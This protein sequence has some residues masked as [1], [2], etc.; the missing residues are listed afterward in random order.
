MS[1]YARGRGIVLLDDYYYC[2]AGTRDSSNTYQSFLLMKLDYEGEIIQ[3]KLHHIPNNNL[4]PGIVG[5]TLKK[6]LDNNLIFACHAEDFLL[7]SVYSSM[8]KFDTSLNILWKNDYY[9]DNLFTTTMNCNATTD[10]GYI[11]SGSVVHIYGDYYDFLLLKTDSLGNMEWHQTYGTEWSEHGQNAIQTPDGG[12]LIGGFYWKPGWDHSLDAMVVKTDS[13][14]N[15][16]WTKYFG[17]PNIDDNMAFVALADDGNY[18]VATV[19]GEWIHT[20]DSRTGELIIYKIDTLGNIISENLYGP[21]RRQLYLKNFKKTENGYLATGWSYYDTVSLYNSSGWMYKFNTNL[22]SVFRREYLHFNEAYDINYLYDATPTSD[23]GY[24]A[25]GK[26]NEGF[27]NA[28]M[29]VLKVDSMGC[30]TAGCATGTFVVEFSPSGG[31]QGEELKVWPNPANKILNVL[32]PIV[33][34]RQNGGTGSKGGKEL[35]LTVYNS[36]GVKVEEIEIHTGKE[37]VTVNVQ[38][39]ESGIYYLRMT[40]G[41]RN[42]GSGK[43]VVKK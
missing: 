21:K 33:S 4:Y 32:P 35:R 3:Q 40:A 6:T 20:P 18:L 34:S 1:N 2:I 36:Q 23:N 14:G 24:V 26:A 42:L 38:G 8:V 7:N 30:D 27:T 15:E 16:Q 37:T 9:T 41:G 12:Y 11:L 43:V 19:Y 22:D 25:I 28:N 5:G 17:N 13:L 31:G 10:G 29:W 39:W